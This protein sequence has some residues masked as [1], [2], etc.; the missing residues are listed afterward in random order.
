MPSLTYDA[1]E[2]TRWSQVNKG[3]KLAEI[4]KQPHPQSFAYPASA[5][6]RCP[7]AGSCLLEI[8]LAVAAVHL[9]QRARAVVAHLLRPLPLLP[10]CLLQ[11][12]AEGRAQHAVRQGGGMVKSGAHSPFQLTHHTQV[13]ATQLA[14]RKPT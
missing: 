2:T 6:T 8:L 9:G 13:S 4:S 3:T 10:L 7:C 14:I 1:N 12:P 5:L 11:L